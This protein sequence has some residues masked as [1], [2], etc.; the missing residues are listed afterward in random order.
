L[1]AAWLIAVQL[2]SLALGG[3]LAGRLRTRWADTLEDE[4][5]F[6]DTAHGLMVW[7]V[8]AVFVACLGLAAASAVTGAAR[9]AGD[10]VQAAGSAANG[11]AKQAAITSA[12]DPTAYFTDMFFRTDHPLT[13]DQAASS[14][15]AAR[16]LGRSLS[17]GELPDA[18]KTYLGQVVA[19]RTGM[20]AADAEKRVS[21]VFSNA[22]ATMAQAADKAREAAD[23][24]R[25]MGIYVALWTFVALLVGA[26]SASYMAT[27]GGHARD[28]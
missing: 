5:F 27:A 19:S 2:F 3:Y 6:R 4:V 8:S 15:E 22:K 13:N 7:A 16:I 23:V 1:T 26:F 10:A 28:V 9:V 11:A 21:E 14:A 18:D 12:A 17:S 25:K 20:S 24:A